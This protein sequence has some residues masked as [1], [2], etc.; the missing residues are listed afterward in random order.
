MWLDVVAA[1]EH[2]S[3]S[4]TPSLNIGTRPTD[5]RVSVVVP[6]F[7]EAGNIREL[8]RQLS[9]ALPPG[10]AAEVVFVDDST[11][12]TADVIA[13][14]AKDCAIPVVLVRRARP[15]GGLGGAVV[16]GLRTARAPWAVV[17]DADLQH[18]PSLVPQL[19]AAG[20]TSDVDLVV[21]TRYAEGGSERG[22]GSAYRRV[23]SSASTALSIAAL[24]EPAARLSDPM[25]GFF[26]VRTAALRLDLARPIGYKVLLELVLRSK[27]TRIAHVPYTFRTRHAGRSKSTPREGVRFLRHLMALRT[28]Q[29]RD[30]VEFEIAADDAPW[31]PSGRLRPARSVVPGRGEPVD[32]ADT[33]GRGLNVLV[34]TSEAPPI[35]SGISRCVDRLTHGLRERGHNV[36][37]LSSVQIPR[38][39][40]GEW[41]FSSLAGCWPGLARR[42]RGYDVINLH[43]PVPTMSDVFLLLAGA[44]GRVPIVYTH[45]SALAIRGLERICDVYNRLHR[46]LAGRADLILTTSEHYA[47]TELVPGGPPTRVVP[48]GVDIRPAVERPSR[49]GPLRV[50][51]VGQ[52]R[53]YKGLEWLLP[54]VAGRPELALTLV[55]DGPRRRVYEQTAARLG[56]DN[57]RFLGRVPDDVLHAEY[58]ASDVVVLPSV[59]QAEAFGLVVLEGMAAGCVPVV[60]DLP[61]VRDVVAEAGVVVHPRDVSALRTALLE[62]AADDANREHL[63]GLAR[64][65]AESLSWDASSAATRTPCWRSH[66]PAAACRRSGQERHVGVVDLRVQRTATA[67]GFVLVAAVAAAAVLNYGFGVALVWLLPQDQFGVVGVLQNL[68][69]LAAFVL[70]AGFPWAVARA[71]ARGEADGIRDADVAVRGGILGNVALGVLL[72]AG[73]VAVQMS[74]VPLLPSAGWASTAAV[75]CALVLLS[76]SNV[77]SGALQGARRFDAVGVTGVSEIVVKV[78]LGLALVALLGWGVSGVVAAVLVGVVVAV[79]AAWWSA[80]DK[81]PGYGP[82]AGG[83]ALRQAAPMALGT[84]AFGLLATLDVLLLSTLG[85]EHGVTAATVAV[86]Q[87]ASILARAPY[88]LSDALS[89]AVFPFVAGGRTAKEAHRW[90]MTAFRWVP[91]VFVPAL[92]VLVIAPEPVVGLVFPGSYG[93]AA[94]VARV[95]AVGTIGLI[96]ADMVRKA[97]FAR[98][99]AGAVALHLPIAAAVQ[100]LALVVLVPPLG[101]V[102]AACAFAMGTW[103]ATGLLGLLYVRHHRPG[104]MAP[105]TVAAWTSAIAVLGLL[106]CGAAAT[107]HPFDLALVAVGVIAYAAMAVRL[108]LLP[109]ALLA[110]VRWLPVPGV[111]LG[112]VPGWRT[113]AAVA[114][115]CSVAC[116]AFWW[117]VG[118]SPDTM[119]DEVSYVVAAQNVARD[120]SLTWTNQPVFVHPPLSFLAEAGWLR[121]L[122]AH[123]A[124]IDEAV[125]IGRILASTVSVIAVLLIGLIATRIATAA[126]PRRR[127]V[128]GMV[129]V[130]L[131]AT[132]PILLR[133]LR[134]VLIEPF[135]LLASALALLFAIALRRQPALIYVPAVGLT[136]G[137]ALLTKEVSIVLVTVPVVHALLS[138]DGRAFGRTAGALAAGVAIWL[139]FPLWAVQ[140]GL[141]SQF[142]SEKLL[143]V[144]RLFGLVQTT[145]WNRPGFSFGSFLGAVLDAASEYTSSYVLLAAGFVALVWLVLHR[146]TEASRWL[147]AWLLLSYGYASYTVLLGSL[148]EHL[149]VFVMP[150]AIV[151]TVLVADAVVARSMAIARSHGRS[152]RRRLVVPVAA[153]LGVLAFATAGWVRSYVPDGDGVFRSAAYV[154]AAEA[155]CAVNAIGDGGKWAPALPGHLVTEYATAPAAR[156]HGVL[157]FFLSGK[158]AATGNALP[159]LP[160]WVTANGTLVASFPSTTYRGIELWEV[161]RDPYDPLADVDPVENGVFVTTV[162]SRCAGFLIAD[163]SDGAIASAWHDLGGKAV[164]GPPATARWAEGGEVRQVVAGAVLAASA[165]RDGAALPLVEELAIRYPGPYGEAQLPPVTESAAADRSDRQVL[166][167]LTDPAIAAAY[168]GEPPGSAPPAAL[169]RGRYLLGDPIGPP[170]EMPDDAV[171]QAFAGGVLEHEAGSTDVRAAPVGQLALDVGVVA[172]PEAARTPEPPPPLVE[173]VEPSEPSTAEPFVLS[174]GILLTLY[175]GIPALGIA[176]VGLLQSRRTR[177]RR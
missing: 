151:G 1:S 125:P 27:L 147:L 144:E 17:M 26:A 19:M 47:A 45:H 56:A 34:L 10:L 79:A 83:P 140:L 128:L 169:E 35:V 166:D 66:V 14:A 112:R 160:T 48:W 129:V 51:F 113:A 91:L 99:M 109:D 59:T 90:F 74:S 64:K 50:L 154:R 95:I 134:L 115:C 123:D 116:T 139:P 122:G 43:G 70:T 37:V 167:M 86:Y 159:E 137:I 21:A 141:G 72:A 161:P 106:L 150:A 77:L 41:R 94:D 9:A 164:L 97:L 119:Y 162:G 23:V 38:V 61:G 71:M 155:S 136:T 146:T 36:D 6:T 143:L 33:S 175:I 55:G 176:I 177:S 53:T 31:P 174:L 156:S 30:P 171:R 60:S 131:A 158:D 103:S 75:A 142:G 87:A 67:G 20:E 145:G 46:R 149:F 76:L 54:A 69:S 78:V 100:V 114:A 92:L 57:V 88:F 152:P 63:A 18:P 168:L 133:Y 173:D 102:G 44:R 58:E 52:M 132:D 62:L 32:V 15:A 163:R 8:L 93:G 81:L 3:A 2:T 107:P 111:R 170:A 73:F 135:A 4:G 16:E 148:N 68:L 85:R 13:A 101:A 105:R 7:N 39:A 84:V 49:Q 110:R 108:R 98:G 157:L 5:L 24:G 124:P 172:P 130:T 121:L 82:V 12:E 153:L 89:D 120:W 127:L 22:L 138:R 25:S 118:S 40:V 126:G 96:T 80:R 29:R 165:E 11:D 65:R 42:L 104:R 117:N 28:V